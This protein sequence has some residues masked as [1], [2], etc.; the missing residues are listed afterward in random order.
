VFRLLLAV[1]VCLGV[2]SGSDNSAPLRGAGSDWLVRLASFVQWPEA[3]RNGPVVVGLAG[4]D[5]GDPRAG[6][7]T[8]GSY[9]AAM[10][11]RTRVLIIRRVNTIEEM[12]RCHIVLVGRSHPLQ[13]REL[14]KL[15]D[16][17]ATLTVSS[18]TGFSHM[19]GMVEIREEAGTRLFR[20]NADA[21]RRSKLAFHPGLLSV[22]TLARIETA[23]E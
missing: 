14:L 3:Q 2:A 21:A 8:A 9:P 10:E 19:G 7:W 23:S 11:G 4:I 13:A 6:H 20:L 22:A 5:E 17:A 12:R 18:L 15:L 16:G 1:L